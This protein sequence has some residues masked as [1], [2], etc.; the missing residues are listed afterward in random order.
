M[1]ILLVCLFTVA[2]LVA[3]GSRDEP[4][5]QNP[6]AGNPE[7]I[8][9][10]RQSFVEICS[11]CHGVNG[12]GGRGPSLVGRFVRRL[13]DQQLFSSIQKGVPGT[14]MPPFPLE[15]D[16][17]WRVTAYVRGLAAPAFEHNLPGNADAGRE[18][19]FGAAG[20]SA[21]H[22]IRGQGG[23]LGPD[24]S[25]AGSQRTFGQLREALLDPSARVAGGFEA[26]V[27]KAPGGRETRGIAKYRTN[28][29]M[30]VLDESGKMH[31]I[32]GKAIE[33]VRLVGKSWMPSGYGERLGEGQIQDLLAFLSRQSTRGRS[34]D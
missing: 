11:A 5:K 16:K 2:D 3:Q 23:F 1:R 33:Q 20:C 12:E 19:F 30:R 13:S 7:A 29:T 14:D 31:A 22:M 6:L 28:Y 26:V 8:E 10:G 15:D 24:L 18:L 9:A 25:D 34:D 17:I 4:G 27:L 21:C 32:R